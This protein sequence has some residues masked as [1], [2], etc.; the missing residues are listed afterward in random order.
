MYSISFNS[1]LS[2]TN[3][4]NVNRNAWE[5]C[6]ENFLTIVCKN[7]PPRARILDI[8]CGD[9]RTSIQ[10]MKIAQKNKKGPLICHGIDKENRCFNSQ[11]LPSVIEYFDYLSAINKGVYTP[12]EYIPSYQNITIE[13]QL[14]NGISTTY[15]G[16]CLCNILN[17]I[18]SETQSQLFTQLSQLN[19]D[20]IIVITGFS[21]KDQRMQQSLRLSQLDDNEIKWRLLS[22]SQIQSLCNTYGFSIQY[23]NDQFLTKRYDGTQAI[24]EKYILKKV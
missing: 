8:G 4:D 22:F 21:I 19:K 23:A 9:F 11:H 24:S 2:N 14:A 10:L 18:P 6:D 16:I 7:L 20:S 5:K 1:T 15:D 17:F 3:L 12:L 13:D